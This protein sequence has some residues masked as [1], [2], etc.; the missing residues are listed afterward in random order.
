MIKNFFPNKIAFIT[1][2]SACFIV[3]ATMGLRQTFG[4]FSNDF[5]IDCGISTTEFGLAIAIHAII[6]G[7][8]TPI[9]GRFADKHGGNYSISGYQTFSKRKQNES[10]RFRDGLRRF[11]YVCIS[12]CVKIFHF[13]NN[14][15]K[16]IYNIFCIFI[17][18]VYSCIFDETASS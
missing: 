8:F 14:L 11:R 2:I 17:I 10:S 6:W 13:R 4:L 7:I 1:M 15:A 9:A 16:Y 3:F 18:N 12:Y 5:E